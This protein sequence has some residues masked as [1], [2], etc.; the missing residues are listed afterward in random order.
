MKLKNWRT[1]ERGGGGRRGERDKGERECVCLVPTLSCCKYA[2]VC[3][4]LL[5][6]MLLL[7][8]VCVCARARVRA[9]VCVCVCV[10]VETSA[11]KS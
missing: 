1:R 8:G 4:C 9:C 10:C 5:A 3:A 11:V 2:P 6:C 7:L